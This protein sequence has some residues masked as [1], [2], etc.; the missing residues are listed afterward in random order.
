MTVTPGTKIN[1]HQVKTEKGKRIR[2]EMPGVTI[3]AVHL[4][5]RWK[6]KITEMRVGDGNAFDVR[7]FQVGK[8]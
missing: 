1:V 3:E 4:R 5:V 8:Q 6:D 7:T 2:L